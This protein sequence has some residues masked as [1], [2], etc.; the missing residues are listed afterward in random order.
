MRISLRKA[1]R[2][3]RRQR[4]QVTAVGLTVLLGVL[5]FVATGGAYRNL[6]TSYEGTY[7]RL[8]FAD[9]VAT[10]TDPQALADA[11]TSA[12]ADTARVRTQAD[13]PMTLA[14]ARL[15]GRLVGMPP[16][17]HPRVDDVEVTQG[18]YLSPDDPDGV[19]LEK[20]AAATFGLGPGDTLQVATPAG[21]HTVTVRGVVISAEYLWPA[22]SRQE[23][24]GDPHS[25]AVV[26]ASQ[27]QVQ[28]WSAQQPNQALVLL[29]GASGSTVSGALRAAGASD[30]QTWSD[31]PSDAALT[32]DLN[33]FD[34]MSRVFPLM[35]LTAAGVA[36]YV[37]L[38]RRVL[39]ERPTI[40]TLMAAGARRGLV[41]WHYVLQG[42]LIGTTAAVLGTAIGAPLTVLITRVYTTELGI[43][44]TVVSAHPDLTVEGIALGVLVGALG[45]VVPAVLA[46]RTVPA[47]AMRNQAALPAPG[48][49]S[50]AVSRL[51]RLPVTTRMALRDVVRNPRRTLATMLGSVLGLVLILA[52]VGMMTSMVAALDTQYG[53]VQREDASVVVGPG[54]QDQV[55]R[56]VSGLTGVAAVEDAV[57]ARVTVGF[58]GASYTTDLQGLAPDT[59]MHG[60]VS[61]GRTVALPADGLLAG[62][63]LADRLGVAA[64]D[65][66]TVTDASGRTT[67]VRLA[68]FVDEPLGTLVYGTPSTVESLVADPTPVLLVRF[69]SGLTTAQRDGLRADVTGLDHVLAYTDTRAL[70]TMVDSYLGLFWAFFGVIV[71]LGGVLA[72]AV[73]QV[74]MSVNLVERTTELATLRAAGV[75]V[76]KAAGVLATENLVAIAAGLPIGL[77]AGVLAAQG[78]LGLFGT[79]MFH[80]QLSLGWWVLALAALGV[81]LA[82]AASQ[83]PA[84]R[85]IRRM[86]VARVVRERVT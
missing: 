22:R 61:G 5:M 50:G 13:V 66:V 46:A 6:S 71:A 24:L 53:T 19:L 7:H 25:F 60:F 26:F 77:V 31:N 39:S 3:L 86:D 54:A 8:G 15:L 27:E 68:G 17:D 64:G 52:S 10:G 44:D 16:A 48:R 28:A 29:G 47:E 58:G 73:I 23:V 74:T 11:A 57:A 32:L 12:G 40:G 35:F 84:A 51:R 45:A 42:L 85:S 21:W 78:T 37:L 38:T 2:D 83:V 1:V 56:E 14:G 34:T 75:T 80:L 18:R 30:V 33:G 43:P 81:V 20:H 65:T 55:A 69:D 76:R 9:L 36:A 41:V 79:D 63:G 49:W 72:L 4:T 70:L 62:A 59:S 82:A 67:D